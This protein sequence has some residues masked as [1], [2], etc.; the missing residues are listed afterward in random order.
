MYGYDSHLG[1]VPPP[2]FSPQKTI[3]ILSQNWDGIG[4]LKITTYRLYNRSIPFI[5]N[6]TN[7]Q[8]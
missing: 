1:K 8:D 5:Y 6:I 7:K 2:L 3:F 4:E